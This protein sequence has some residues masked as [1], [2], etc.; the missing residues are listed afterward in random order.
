MVADTRD[1][2]AGDASRKQGLDVLFFYLSDLL[3]RGVRYEDQRRP[4]ARL[5]DIGASTSAPYPQANSIEVKDRRG[6]KSV[7]PW[8]AVVSFSNRG[9][10]IR[11]GTPDRPPPADFWVRRD[12]LDDQVVDVSGARVLRVNDVHLIYSGSKLMFA[13]VEVGLL[14]L[15]RRLR[16]ERPVSFLLRWLFDYSLKEGFVTWRHIE[17]LSPGGVPGGLRVSR[18]NERLT[19][20]HPGDLADILE[21]LGV[22]SRQEVFNALSVET[23]ANALEAVTPEF[24]RT[25]V[26]QG[27]PDRVAEILDEMPTHEA[28]DLLRDLGPDAPAI[29]RRMEAGA[30]TDVSSVLAH[31]EGTAGSVM[32]TDCMEA[33]PGQRAGDVLAHI[34]QTVAERDVYTVIY[35]LDAQRHL[36]GVASLKYLLAAA[37]DA[38][39]ESFMMKDA[40]TVAPQTPLR[41]VARVFI[42]YGFLSLPVVDE[43]GIFLGAVRSSSVLPE[44]TP[45]LKD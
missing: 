37:D 12:V 17:V 42:K 20:M 45:F 19:H 33:A 28:A 35:V 15:L 5:R 13:H 29:L 41:D 39:M 43:H 6:R 44:L 3:G 30:A 25:L 8:S 2:P 18:L 38:S 16:F 24:Q 40:A 27:Q 7:L 10:V 9:V 22:T 26:A 4:F 11:R 14:G 31:R 1:R 32:S 34:R 23:A 21:D 36:V